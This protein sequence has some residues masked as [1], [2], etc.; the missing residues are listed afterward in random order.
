MFLGG[1]NA[2]A[3]TKFIQHEQ[4]DHD[5]LWKMALVAEKGKYIIP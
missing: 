5:N 3:L 1:H 4:D 2:T